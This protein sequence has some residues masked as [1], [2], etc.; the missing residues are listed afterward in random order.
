MRI[1]I[2]LKLALLRHY[3]LIIIQIKATPHTLKFP[4]AHNTTYLLCFIV[5]NNI[6]AAPRNRLVKGGV[7]RR[8]GIVNN[9]ETSCLAHLRKKRE[10]KTEQWRKVSSGKGK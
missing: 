8:T 5:K 6:H 2:S 4:L 10:D 7:E 9:G 3:L 1:K